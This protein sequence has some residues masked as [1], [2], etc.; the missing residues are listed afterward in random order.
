MRGRARPGDPVPATGPSDTAPCAKR[1]V[2]GP[3]LIDGLGM[4]GYLGSGNVR[5]TYFGE[6]YVRT[7]VKLTPNAVVILNHLCYSA[8]SSSRGGPTP[9]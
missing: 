5:T 6:Y 7:Q 8:R 9:R 4:N 1:R 3:R 2:D